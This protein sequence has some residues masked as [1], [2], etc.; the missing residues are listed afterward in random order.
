M[1]VKISN[2]EII[3]SSQQVEKNELLV[4]DDVD[5]L[6][7]EEERKKRKKEEQIE[8][9]REARLKHLNEWKVILAVATCHFFMFILPS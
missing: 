3:S 4:D 6:E 8:K 2:F 5:E 1:L 7:E 9:E